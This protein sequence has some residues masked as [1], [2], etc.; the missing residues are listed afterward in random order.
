MWKSG[1][2]ALGME[3]RGF[4]GVEAGSVTTV[5]GPLRNAPVPPDDSMANPPL[6]DLS[7]IDLD[8]VAVDRAGLDQYL[9]Q[10]GTFAVL[11]HLIHVD[12]EAGLLVGSK[13]IREDDWWA[14][15]HVP[16]RPMFPGALMIETAAQI[17]S[18]DYSKHRINPDGPER[19]VGFGGV[20]DCRFRGVVEP[21]SRLLL[22]VR[23]ERSGSRMFKYASEGHLM[24][25]GVLQT[26]KVFEAKV[27]GV[28]L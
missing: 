6:L 28:L 10:R 18:Y 22:T 19:F 12:V 24:K 1:G 13:M 17:A 11:D 25:D 9:Q 26:S 14:A 16:G 21:P 20:D 3:W 8:Q 7:T 15:D 4:W 2:V 27:I 23:L 5:P